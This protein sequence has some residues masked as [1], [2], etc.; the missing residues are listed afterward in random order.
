MQELF[1]LQHLKDVEE[2][3]IIEAAITCE[4][5]KILHEIHALKI[6]KEKII[7]A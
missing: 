4:T 5:N 2:I 3:A 6:R 1:A 7:D